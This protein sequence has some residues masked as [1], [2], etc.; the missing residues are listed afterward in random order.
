MATDRTSTNPDQVPTPSYRPGEVWRDRDGDDWFVVACLGYDGHQMRNMHDILRPATFVDTKY[1]P[2]TRV[3][4]DLG[5]AAGDPS[6][7]APATGHGPDEADYGALG[8]AVVEWNQASGRPNF[9]AMAEL[10][11]LPSAAEDEA[12]Y[13]REEAAE[14][15]RGE[16]YTVAQLIETDAGSER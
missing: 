12:E 14:V 3:F 5:A 11:E 2:L 4:G 6:S 16:R 15:G 1:G 13:L 8:Y 10:H 7:T 9:P